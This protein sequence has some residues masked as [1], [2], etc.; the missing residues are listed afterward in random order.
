MAHFV[1]TIRVGKV[2]TWLNCFPVLRHANRIGEPTLAL[3]DQ[4]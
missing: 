2:Q 3:T 1:T 4:E